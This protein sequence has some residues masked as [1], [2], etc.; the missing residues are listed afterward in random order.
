MKRRIPM[1][2]VALV[3]FSML[4]I[5]LWCMVPQWVR[6]DY[7]LRVLVYAMINS[8]IALGLNFVVGVTGQ[9]N[10]GQAVFVGVS[11]YTLAILTQKVKASWLW[12]VMAA[13]SAT[14]ILG[15]GLGWISN[16]LRGPYLAVT[17]LAVNL[18]FFLVAS[19]EV[20]LTGGPMGVRVPLINTPRVFGAVLNVRIVYYIVLGSLV[21]LLGI[22]Q[23]I[24]RSKVGR[25]FRTVRDDE[26]AAALMGIN[27]V[28]A[29]VWACIICTFFA[30]VGG[31]LYLLTFRFVCPSEFTALQSFR[32]L[33]MITIG[34]LGNLFGSVLGAFAVTIV[35]EFLRVIQGYWDIILG[36]SIIF[37]LLVFPKGLG[38]IGEY[39]SRLVSRR[40]VEARWTGEFQF[41]EMK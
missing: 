20:W 6:T 24:Y 21:I 35:P 37:I 41:P 1:K 10:L 22:G 32:Y 29:K 16:R 23:L 9:I 2:A 40:E 36:V 12:S 39:V 15:T 8:V 38:F 17:T 4:S 25:A 14:S 11:A 3:I 18:I 28:Q 13:L 26:T 5:A 7:Y 19:H 34:G 31:V 33:A 30:G 27:V